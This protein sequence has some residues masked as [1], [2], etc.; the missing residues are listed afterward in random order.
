MIAFLFFL[1]IYLYSPAKLPS[2][3][4]LENEK[5]SGRDAGGIQ[6]NSGELSSKEFVKIQTLTIGRRI[7]IS[8]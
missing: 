2:S 1:F 7:P 4:S 5:Y 6:S 8:V 3:V